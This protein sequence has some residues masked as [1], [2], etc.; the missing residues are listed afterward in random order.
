MRKIYTHY[1]MNKKK[2][3]SYQVTKK[4][5]KLFFFCT[6]NFELQIIVKNAKKLTSSHVHL[7]SYT[8]GQISDILTIIWKF[9]GFI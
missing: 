3:N 9:N 2:L 8:Y 6:K 1:L 7:N 4:I 5:S